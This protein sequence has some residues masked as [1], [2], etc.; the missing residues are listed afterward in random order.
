[1]SS[2]SNSGGVT[3]QGNRTFFFGTSSGLNTSAL[4]EAAYNQR[5]AEA[6][7]IDVRIEKNN[8]RFDAYTDLQAKASSIQTALQSLRKSYS[9]L[10]TNAS[11]FDARAG[12]LTSS[13]STTNPATLLS[14][15]VD[16][17]ADK[18]SYEI[19][20]IQKAKNHRVASNTF[21]DPTVALGLTGSFDLGVAGGSTSPVNV[22]AGMN[23]N[24]L[25]T[26]INAT[27]DT[28]G[29]SAYVLKVNTNDYQ[30]IIAAEDTA[31]QIQIT[32]VA[33]TNVMDS[34]GVT[35]GGLFAN[36]LQTADQAILELD[37]IPIY[38]DSNVIDDLIDGVELSVTKQEPGTIL[39]LSIGNDN[40]L[41]KDA[42]L[43][44][45]EAYNTLRDFI[46]TNQTVAS[47]GDVADDA[48]LFSDLQMETLSDYLQNL[49]GAN[50]GS[51][52]TNLATLRELGITQDKSTKL[53]G[54]E[55]TLD[56]AIATKFDQ[57]RAI[58]ER[59]VTSNNADFRMISNSS[60]LAADNITFDITVTAGSITG[61]LANGDGT[62]FDFSGTSITGKAG[63]IYEGMTF[64]YVGAASATVSF[65]MTQGIADLMDNTIEKFADVTGSIEKEKLSLIDQNDDMT[66]RADRIRERADEF[67]DNLI[68]KYA[69]FEAQISA[70]KS[71]LAQIR[72]ILGTNNNDN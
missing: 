42:V 2:I 54:N 21:V 3:T 63:S 19:E 30:L 53:V 69:K 9:F 28:S 41:V 57:V 38:R 45:V 25:A 72:A 5:I 29:V 65:S 14:V 1:M 50:Y 32:N 10:S 13:V 4:I 11:A 20:I 52:G 27:T 48:V 59:S 8:A 35:A 44:F 12:T 67:R 55:V 70:A 58:F 22:T 66:L 16:P 6:D 31:K 64:A 40:S 46:I 36:E 7:K 62:L 47:N 71:V 39:T 51:G 61:V 24:D 18:G 37:G 15:A 43:D 17:A 26:A 33:G 49:V 60:T 23:L 34:I 68:E 56:G